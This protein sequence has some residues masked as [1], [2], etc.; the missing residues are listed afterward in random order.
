MGIREQLIREIERLPE[1]FI[2]EVYDFI[3]FM[4]KRRESKGRDVGSWGDFSLSIG[5]FDFWED[6]EEAEYS[7][8]DLKR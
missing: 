2:K 5:A 1:D 8:E 4:R 7:L 3:A 6:P